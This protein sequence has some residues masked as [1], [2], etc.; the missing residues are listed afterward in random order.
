MMK[1]LAIWM[2]VMGLL[3]GC[4]FAPAPQG[5]ASP[6]VEP[7]IFTETPTSEATLT[8][9]VT[10]T[11]DSPLIESATPTDTPGPPT[12]PPPPTATQGPYE[13]TIQA[14]D[15]LLYVIQLYGY[16]DTAVIPEI[17][18]MNDNILNADS[19]PSVGSVILIP[20]QTATPIPEGVELTPTLFAAQA[21]APTDANTGLNVN[22]SVLEHRVLEGET[23]VDIATNYATTLEVIA[24]LNPEIAFFGCDFE[25]PSG[26]PNCNPLL[27]VDQIVQVPA[28]TPTPTLSPTPDGNE[29]ATPTP[30]Y[31]PPEV[32]SPQQDAVVPAGIFRLEWVGVGVLQPD[33]VYL[34]QITN[35]ITGQVYNDIT[36]SNSLRMPNSLLPP[37]GETHVINWTVSVA[38]PNADGVYRIISGTPGIRTFKWQG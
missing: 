24:R 2:G 37:A 29:T 7:I 25:T 9:S 20:R 35:T 22:T 12:I 36:R 5:D 15:T 16:R 26:G 8:P 30:T 4:N 17:V 38:K 27:Q 21:L 23:I 18:R 33:E 13:H 1:S 19:L 11:P 6:T 10:P 34:V 14:N 32:V 3:A 28:P 31:L